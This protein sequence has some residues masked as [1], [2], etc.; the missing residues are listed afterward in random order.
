VCRRSASRPFRDVQAHARGSAQRLIAQAAVA[1]RGLPHCRQELA[2]LLISEQFFK[3]KISKVRHRRLLSKAERG[4]G[5]DE[6]LESREITAEGEG[7]FFP[8]MQAPVTTPKALARA[9]IPSRSPS[10]A[11]FLSDSHW[12]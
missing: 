2:S 5:D 6:R 4:G 3:W 9:C 7:F 1:D 12:D 10:P 11:V 8:K